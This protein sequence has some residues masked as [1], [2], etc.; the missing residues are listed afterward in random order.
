MGSKY[1]IYELVL[2]LWLVDEYDVGGCVEMTQWCKESSR[3]YLK[4]SGIT[5]VLTDISA[6]NIVKILGHPKKKRC[7][8][9]NNLNH[10][11]VFATFLE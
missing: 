5:E 7:I 2:G 8:S 10:F 1:Q 9:K 4:L 11:L 6:G 3:N